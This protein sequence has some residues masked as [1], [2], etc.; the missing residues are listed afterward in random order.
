MFKKITQE[1]P[2]NYEA[3][4]NNGKIL[5]S[6]QRYEQAIIQFKNAE[7]IQKKDNFYLYNDMAV[8]FEKLERYEE[9][10][11]YADLADRAT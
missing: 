4:I 5:I 9:A 11:H 3:L 1:N 2:E 7:R 10:L 6:Q 8:A